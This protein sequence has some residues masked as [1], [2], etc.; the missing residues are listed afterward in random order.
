MKTEIKFA[1]NTN[2]SIEKT[3]FEIQKLLRKFAVN[4]IAFLY[5]E[6]IIM[7]ELNGKAIRIQLKEPNINNVSIQK[8]PSGLQRKEEAI[9]KLYQQKLRQKWRIFHFLLKS[10][11][12]SIQAEVITAEQFFIPYYITKDNKTRIYK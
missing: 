12:I 9:Q 5:D 2:V 10:A 1:E 7:F 4:K 6:N 8:T 11:I 3:Q